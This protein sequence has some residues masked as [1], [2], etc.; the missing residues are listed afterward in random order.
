MIEHYKIRHSDYRNQANN[1]IRIYNQIAQRAL[2]YFPKT[3]SI[4]I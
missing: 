4:T 1:V 3:K 2:Q